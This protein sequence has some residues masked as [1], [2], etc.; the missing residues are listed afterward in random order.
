MNSAMPFAGMVGVDTALDALRL[1]AIDP[2][3]RGVVIGA[4]V[5]SGKSTLA[6]ASTVLYG[7]QVPFVELPLGSDED[8]LLGGID[9][10]ATLRTGRRVVRPG[11]LGRAHH[12]VLYV[13]ALNLV[14]D[15]VVNILLGVI[16]TRMVR[17]ERE[18][19]SQHMACDMRVIATYDPAEGLPRR[20][21][22]DRLGLM[23]L[24]PRE[25][26][27]AQRYEVLQRHHAGD[28]TQCTNC[29]SSMRALSVKR[30]N[31]CHRSR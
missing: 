21:L 26:S 25:S 23:V 14:P 29:R 3:L 24:L 30:G 16:D 10:E 27:L 11:M 1:L 7:A 12:G 4:P 15:A 22:L 18:G 13:D 6:R 9:I 17:L 2:R 5:G 28:L 19:V 31:C 8:G 20:H